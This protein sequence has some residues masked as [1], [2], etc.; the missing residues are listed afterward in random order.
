MKIKKFLKING[1]GGCTM[2]SMGDMYPLHQSHTSSGGG[3][4]YNDLPVPMSFLPSGGG[5]GGTT[6]NH[7]STHSPIPIADLAAH[8]DKLKM[9]NNALFTQVNFEFY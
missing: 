6:R 5:V 3:A 8:I 7:S 9:N 1:N 4:V 2:D